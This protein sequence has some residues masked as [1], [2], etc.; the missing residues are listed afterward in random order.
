M[1]NARLEADKVVNKNI[2]LSIQKYTALQTCLEEG[3]MS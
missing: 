1:H 3:A 2:D